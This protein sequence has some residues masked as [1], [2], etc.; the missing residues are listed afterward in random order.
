M[1]K[2]NCFKPV[3]V[4]WNC[5]VLSTQKFST[6]D[7]LVVALYA[8]FW[9]QLQLSIPYFDTQKNRR[10]IWAA[11]DIFTYCLLKILGNWNDFNSLRVSVSKLINTLIFLNIFWIYSFIFPNPH[12][13][14]ED[15]YWHG[16]LVLVVNKKG[17]WKKMAFYSNEILSQNL[18]ISNEWLL[19][20]FRDRPCQQQLGYDY[21]LASNTK[22]SPKLNKHIF[23][24]HSWK[25]P[26][27]LV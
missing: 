12:H 13:L 4:P 21:R 22:G 5:G 18:Y 23:S 26:K 25:I 15:A 7:F 20:T 10:Q 2:I 9:N 17:R 6:E 19:G 11:K 24:N 16:H 3:R 1:H 8:Q 27:Y 14:S